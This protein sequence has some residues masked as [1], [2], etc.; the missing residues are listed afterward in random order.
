[1]WG[2]ETVRAVADGADVVGPLVVG[3]WQALLTTLGK[4][5]P[6]DP[7][8]SS[9]TGRSPRKIHS[10]LS[11]ELYGLPT[12]WLRY[13]TPYWPRRRAKIGILNFVSQCVNGQSKVVYG[14][15]QKICDFTCVAGVVDT[16]QGLLESDRAESDVVD[17]GSS[18]N[19]P[20]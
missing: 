15:G 13:F 12:V 4:D 2:P 1:M 3:V 7:A 14:D 6:T 9:T 18:D 20:I 17:I 5:Q 19:I 8:K 16:N 10:T 11:T